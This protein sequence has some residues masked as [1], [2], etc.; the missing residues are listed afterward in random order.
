MLE[1]V[2]GGREEEEWCS[3]VT[4][5]IFARIY[6]PNNRSRVPCAHDV[7][8]CRAAQC[9]HI[10]PPIAAS[11]A[12]SVAS[13]SPPTVDTH[14]AA[15]SSVRHACRLRRSRRPVWT[16]NLPPTAA[17]VRLSVASLSPPSVDTQFAA[18]SSVRHAYRSRRSRRP[19]WTYNLPPTAA[20]VTLVVRVALAA[21]CRHTFCRRQ[22]RPSRLSVAS[23]SPPS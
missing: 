16:H 23:L 8:P 18:D 17:S 2:L 9:G 10:L 3:V 7:P 21:Q 12:L 1:T 20:F 11:V 14:F 6:F 19:V 4:V 15:D 13:L 5:F 22:Q